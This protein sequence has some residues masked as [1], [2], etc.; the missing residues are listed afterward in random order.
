MMSVES[1]WVLPMAS[2]FLSRVLLSAR[3][4]RW[5]PKNR[6]KRHVINTQLE[7]NKR[8]Q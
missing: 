2:M 3:T 7:L 1:R 5:A 6:E 4:V 8:Q